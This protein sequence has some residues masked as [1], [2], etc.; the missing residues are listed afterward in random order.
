M[1]IMSWQ[2]EPVFMLILVLFTVQL[3]IFRVLHLFHYV[4]LNQQILNLFTVSVFLQI[5]LYS[6]CATCTIELHSELK[7]DMAE[8]FELFLHFLVMT[9]AL[10]CLPCTDKGRHC[11]K[12]FIASSQVF[13]NKFFIVQL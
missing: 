11:F 8:I 4:L 10:F 6:L 7:D 13:K 9:T 5:S 12:Y 1:L 3:E 2:P